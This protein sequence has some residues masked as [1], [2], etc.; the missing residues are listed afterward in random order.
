VGGVIAAVS[1]TGFEAT[2]TTTKFTSPNT[3]GIDPCGDEGGGGRPYSPP[4]I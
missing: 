1:Q 4:R 3:V 2:D